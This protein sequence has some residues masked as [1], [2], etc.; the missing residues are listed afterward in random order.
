[1]PQDRGISDKSDLYICHTGGKHGSE[2]ERLKVTLAKD[3]LR[4]A[5]LCLSRDLSKHRT[6]KKA[7]Q[8]LIELQ[9]TVTLSTLHARTFK[10]E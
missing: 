5:L 10:L 2:N 4:K 1:M 6:S 9:N 7:E 3:L 8:G